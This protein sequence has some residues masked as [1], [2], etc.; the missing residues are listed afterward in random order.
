MSEPAKKSSG[1]IN[2]QQIAMVFAVEPRTV[3]KWCNELGMPKSGRGQYNLVECVQWRCG[4]LEK[5]IKT[6]TE[7]G[8][9]GMN[10][11]TRLKKV[12]SEIK[13]YHLAKL[14][15]ELVALYEIMPVI[16]EGLNR[17]RQR[18]QS[19]GQ[20]TAPQLQ[21]LEVTEMAET[22]QEHIN[23]LFAD[24]ANIPNALRRLEKF[25]RYR[26]TE[27]VRDPETSAKDDGQPVGRGKKNAK[28]GNKSRTRKVSSK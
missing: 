8:T 22:L 19:F 15:G 20:R 12:N 26:T 3:T 6:L 9:E 21:G 11:G 7:G 1:T 27:G 24:L 4:Y 14:R 25:A 13:E 23:E 17:I 5:K 10:Q 18:S 16:T 28:P 2:H